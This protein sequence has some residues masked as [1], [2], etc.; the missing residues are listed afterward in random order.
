MIVPKKAPE[1][2]L[3]YWTAVGFLGLRAITPYVHG[4]V[5]TR[6]EI[7]KISC[8]S[9]SSVDVIYVQPP[10]VNVR[11]MPTPITNLGSVEFGLRV[12]AYHSPT[13][14]NRGPKQTQYSSL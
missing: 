10:H 7:I 1:R 14:A 11:K 12:R 2:Y 13:R 9:W 6:Y 8:Q 3:R 4:I 5:D